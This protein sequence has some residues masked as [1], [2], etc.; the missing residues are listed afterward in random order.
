[1]FSHFI[2]FLIHSPSLSHPAARL[3]L[4]SIVNHNKNIFFS[5]P[6]TL[7]RPFHSHSQY[8][9]VNVSSL[10]FPLI[11]L[12]FFS[13]ISRRGILRQMNFASMLR[14]EIIARDILKACIF[15]RAK[16]A[17]HAH[18][19]SGLMTATCHMHTSNNFSPSHSRGKSEKKK[20]IEEENS[21]TNRQPSI[22]FFSSTHTS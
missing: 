7:T 11:E 3:P 4:L 18:D 17:S 9:A 20:R 2:I 5:Y 13:L 22:V 16:R 8:H 6:H 12:Y 10:G 21:F 1:M 15:E 14:I 19:R